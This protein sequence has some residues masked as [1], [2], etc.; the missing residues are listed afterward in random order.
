[1]FIHQ[2]KHVY[3]FG[4]LEIQ[5]GRFF[6]LHHDLK[7]YFS[8]GWFASSGIYLCFYKMET[9]QAERTVETTYQHPP[10]GGV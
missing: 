9:I 7:N 6:V 5:K 10:R 2:K 8:K 3:L 4:L 1:M